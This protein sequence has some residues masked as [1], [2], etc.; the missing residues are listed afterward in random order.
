MRRAVALRGDESPGLLEEVSGAMASLP[1]P[2]SRQEESPRSTGGRM[3]V[4]DEFI[5]LIV[6]FSMSLS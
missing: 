2:E 4:R 6:A 3:S 5:K 1:C